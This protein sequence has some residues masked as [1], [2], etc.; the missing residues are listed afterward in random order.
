VTLVGCGASPRPVEYTDLTRQAGRLEFTRITRQVFRDRADFVDY[1]ERANP[2]RRLEMP[3]VDFSRRRVFLVATGP[4]SST[5]YDLSVVRAVDHGGHVTVVVRE[6]TPSL[7][8]PVRAG[9]T[10]PFVL[11]SLPRS[12]KPIRLR[13]PG[14][15]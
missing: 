8:E 6:R 11:I 9:V 15:P 13:W 7:G 14:R 4:R 5:G 1:L 12:D 2:G 3:R 10:Y